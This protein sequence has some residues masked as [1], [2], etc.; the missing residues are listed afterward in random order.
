MNRF[1]VS[2]QKRGFAFV[3][4][5]GH[6]LIQNAEEK[7]FAVVSSPTFSLVNMEKY[8]FHKIWHSNKRKPEH[9]QVVFQLFIAIV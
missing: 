8:G 5:V 3:Y 1:V 6:Q 9:G 2:I 7:R 4:V